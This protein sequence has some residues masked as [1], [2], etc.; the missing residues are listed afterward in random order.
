FPPREVETPQNACAVVGVSEVARSVELVVCLADGVLRGF[1][2]GRPLCG[3]IATSHG[4]VKLRLPLGPNRVAD[5]R[6]VEVG[7]HVNLPRSG[8]R[9]RRRA[10]V[11]GQI[12]TS[13]FFS[14]A[15]FSRS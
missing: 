6:N 15:F 5:F 4:R 2:L 1:E 14:S 12:R 3:C 9:S 8:T 13:S 11:G 10:R 7:S